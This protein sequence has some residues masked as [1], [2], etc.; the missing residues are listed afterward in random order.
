LGCPFFLVVTQ[1]ERR[2]KM[3]QNK[4]RFSVTEKTR[5]IEKISEMLLKSDKDFRDL[6]Q[7]LDAV[8]SIVTNRE[9][10]LVQRN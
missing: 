2:I 3:E 10:Q 7:I 9:Y 8:I 5:L 1:F 4:K 6:L